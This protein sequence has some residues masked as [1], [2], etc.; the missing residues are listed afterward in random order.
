MLLYARHLFCIAR[1]DS[2][3]LKVCAQSVVR[4]YFKGT[5]TGE[6]KGRSVLYRT[7]R[8]SL[9][10]QAEV[11]PHNWFPQHIF[12]FSPP[13]PS[14]DILHLSLFSVNIFPI[15]SLPHSALPLSLSLFVFTFVFLTYM[16]AHTF[17]GKAW[18]F[19]LDRKQNLIL[20]RPANRYVGS[21]CVVS[22]KSYITT[23]EITPLAN[24]SM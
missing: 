23:D 4:A 6:I 22:Y 10:E 9:A 24:L 2:G 21:F 3:S 20:F 7:Q 15:W 13:P 16:H 19:V 5:L 12:L 17:C 14:C 1:R 8:L 18:H 11:D